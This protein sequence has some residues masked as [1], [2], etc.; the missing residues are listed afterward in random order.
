MVVELSNY[1]GFPRA[2]AAVRKRD[3][4]AQGT[5]GVGGVHTGHTG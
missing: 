4:K 5:V 3:Q 1:M 2:G